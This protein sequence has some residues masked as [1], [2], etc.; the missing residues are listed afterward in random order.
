MDMNRAFPSKTLTAP[1]LQGRTVNVVIAAIEQVSYQ[2]GDTGFII[3]FQGKEKGMSLNK[4]KN[5]ILMAAFGADSNNWVGK[6][7]QLSPGKTTYMG[8]AVD[9]INVAI[10]Q[11]DGTASFDPTEPQNPAPA[12]PAQGGGIAAASG[13]DDDDVP[14]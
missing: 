9:C 14:F 3:K 1:D 11:A 8:N 7:V 4:T 12:P 2:S 5:A 10:P 13:I 6:T